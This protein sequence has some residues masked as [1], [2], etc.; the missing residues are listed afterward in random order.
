MKFDEELNFLIDMKLIDIDEFEEIFIEDADYGVKS[1]AI[2]E[3]KTNPSVKIFRD[4]KVTL[5]YNY[6]DINGV[7]LTEFTIA[8]DQ[9][10]E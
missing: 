3:L 7:F 6:R 5:V 9:Y 10:N 4:N 8:P 2:N 1:W